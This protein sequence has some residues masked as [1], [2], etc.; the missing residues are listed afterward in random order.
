VTGLAAAVRPVVVIPA[1]EPGPGF[2]SLV[3]TLVAEPDQAVIV[4]NDGSAQGHAPVFASL[5]ALEGVTVL[6][7]PSN[8][9]K[10]CALRTA[11]AHFLSHAG[12]A[13][14]G[15]VTADADGQHLAVDIQAMGN[16]LAAAP[17]ALWLGARTFEGRVPLRSRFGNGLTQQIFRLLLGPTLAD[18]QTGLR[19]IPRGFLPDLVAIELPRYEFELEML[20]QA[21]RS[22]MRIR[23]LPVHTVY[24]PGNP[25]SHFRPLV[26]SLKVYYVFVRFL[27]IGLVTA[28]L[29]FAVFSVCYA[30]GMSLFGSLATARF[31]AGSFN[32]TMNHVLVFQ[33]GEP[34]RATVPRYVAGVL[35]HLGLAY[36]LVDKLIANL[37]FN[38]YLAKLLA[39]GLLVLGSFTFQRLVVFPSRQLAS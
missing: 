33:S 8:L 39:E 38:T 18:T 37:D 35:L 16:A 14:P 17:D 4:V 9:G 27:G 1:F 31:F 28:T 13:C 25:S 20:V 32:F 15:V 30:L 29:D 5:A 7:H 34:L 21:V 12:P 6:Q 26:D 23:E 36:L 11:F 24:E 3:R 22:G 19:G 10:G 2:E